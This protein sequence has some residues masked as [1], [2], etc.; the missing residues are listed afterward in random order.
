MLDVIFISL[1][2]TGIFIL[3]NGE[4]M[5]FEGLGNFI[6]MH[7][8]EVFLKPFFGCLPCMASVWT[9]VYTYTFA[10]FNIQTLFVML[11]VCGLNYLIATKISE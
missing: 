6:R 1:F 2:C 3:F 10:E 5:L 8:D 4:G 11:A 9:C 7:I